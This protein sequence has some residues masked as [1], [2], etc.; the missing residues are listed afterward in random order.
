MKQQQHQELSFVAGW[1]FVLLGESL[2]Y[3]CTHHHLLVHA[4]SIPVNQTIWNNNKNCGCLLCEILLQNCLVNP[5]SI[6]SCA[7][8]CCWFYSWQQ[9]NMIQQQ[10][11]QLPLLAV[12]E[13]MEQQQ[14]Q[15]SCLLCEIFWCNTIPTASLI[16]PWCILSWHIYNIDSTQC[17]P[18]NN[19]MIQL[20]KL[21]Y[22]LC[23]NLQCSNCMVN[24]WCFLSWRMHDNSTPTNP[25]RCFLCENLLLILCKL[26]KVKHHWFINHYCVQDSIRPANQTIWNNNNNN[27]N[28]Y[29]LTNCTAVCANLKCM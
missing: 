20:Q 18:N 23:E 16:N 19:I 5:Q 15:L 21:W 10:E 12:W 25:A 2:C 9:N 6:L 3:W 4:D 8:A 27:N 29:I 14:Q 13:F 7:H 28:R 11:S 1:E 17:Q 24:L 26:L 22:L